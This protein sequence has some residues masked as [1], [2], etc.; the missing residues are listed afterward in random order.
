M[1]LDVLDD[2]FIHDLSLEAFERAF[3]ALPS[4]NLYFSQQNTSFSN[5]DR[6]FRVAASDPIHSAAGVALPL[7]A[8]SA[9]GKHGLIQIPITQQAWFARATERIAIGTPRAETPREARENDHQR[10]CGS[11]NTSRQHNDPS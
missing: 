5:R 4:I 7:S 8:G 6:P 1:A 10:D 11:N 9:L 2:V 3:E